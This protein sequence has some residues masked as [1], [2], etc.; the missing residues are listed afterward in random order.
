[1]NKYLPKIIKH[2]YFDDL[3]R[4]DGALAGNWNPT[5]TTVWTREDGFIGFSK[6][7]KSHPKYKPALELLYSDGSW[8]G[9]LCYNRVNNENVFD[10]KLALNIINYVHEKLGLEEI[11][12]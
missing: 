4:I 7:K 5:V 1:M 9:V 11:I 10:E 8:V 3:E 2:I 12:Q 6:V